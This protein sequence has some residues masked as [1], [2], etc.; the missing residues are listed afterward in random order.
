MIGSKRQQWP[1]PVIDV[2]GP[3]D[4]EHAR[5]VAEDIAAKDSTRSE[6]LRD[7]RARHIDN[8]H[9]LQ[10][11]GIKEKMFDNMEEGYAFIRERMA[12]AN[13]KFGISNDLIIR[14]QMLDHKIM[15]QRG[16][17][18][19]AQKLELERIS[20][21]LDKQFAKAGVEMSGSK[22]GQPYNFSRFNEYMLIATGILSSQN[23]IS[24][25]TAAKL[26][27]KEIQEAKKWGVYWFKGA[28]IS[29]F[30]TQ[31]PLQIPGNYM[32][33]QTGRLSMARSNLVVVG[34]NIPDA[35]VTLHGVGG[36]IH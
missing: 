5:E 18:T 28:E 29:Y 7:I 32:V 30:I 36:R 10:K 6:L 35:V 20:K 16:V 25:K 31:P 14:G 15:R 8:F 23:G 1:R 33:H 11:S 12:I 17:A 26:A 21:T 9:L 24:P 2:H 27:N 19:Y 3:E 34:T 22:P 4:I 13:A